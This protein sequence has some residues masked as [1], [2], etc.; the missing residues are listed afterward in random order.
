MR[1]LLVGPGSN[2]K[3]GD[4]FYYS[5]SRRLLNG[6]VRNGHFVLHVSDRD[7]ADYALGLRSIGA[8]YANRRLREIAASLQPD[9]LVLVHADLVT[10]ETVAAVR[11]VSP[12]TKVAVAEFD[13][14]AQRSH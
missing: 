5:F 4:R 12:A 8:I 10:D 6:F 2:R 13:A 11:K 7:L 9:L 3:F 14:L 1:I